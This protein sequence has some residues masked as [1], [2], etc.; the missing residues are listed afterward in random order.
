MQYESFLMTNDKCLFACAMSSEL[1]NAS[2]SAKRI[3]PELCTAGISACFKRWVFSVLFCFVGEI[4]GQRQ[5]KGDLHLERITPESW[6]L[7]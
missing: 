5:T 2:G 7:T 6:A 3:E 4:R 1:K